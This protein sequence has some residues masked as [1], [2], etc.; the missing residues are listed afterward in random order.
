MPIGPVDAIPAATTESVSTRSPWNW[1]VVV[2][3]SPSPAQPPTM[4]TPAP[5][6]EYAPRTISSWSLARPSVRSSS[7][8]WGWPAGE[9]RQRAARAPAPRRSSDAPAAAAVPTA[10]PSPPS[11][12]TTMLPSRGPFG[13]I[14]PAVVQPISGTPPDREWIWLMSAGRLSD[15]E[16]KT[17]SSLA[18]S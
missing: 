7:T 1:N 2:I 16:E 3:F 9:G 10:K 14:S 13:A 8:W 18:P 11:A 6:T 12:A 15:T 17:I 5:S 4:G